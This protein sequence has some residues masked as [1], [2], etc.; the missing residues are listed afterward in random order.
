MMI[1][2]G[3]VTKFDRT[4]AELEEFALFSILVAGKTAKTMVA[5]LDRF[6]NNTRVEGRSYTPFEQIRYYNWEYLHN[7]F[8]SCGIGCYRQKA[9]TC[10]ETFNCTPYMIKTPPARV[11]SKSWMNLVPWFIRKTYSSFIMPD[12]EAW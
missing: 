8:K 4:T 3:E 11:Y 7:Q 10:L 5:A 1:D 9:G 6:L 12:T 2:L